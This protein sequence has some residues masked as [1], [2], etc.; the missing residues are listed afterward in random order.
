MASLPLLRQ[1]PRGFGE[2]LQRAWERIWG[3]PRFD[4]R[5]KKHIDPRKTDLQVFRSLP[6]TDPWVD[7]KLPGLFIYL[8]ERKTSVIPSEWQPAM[9]EMHS[10]MQKYVAKLRW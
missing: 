4:L 10:E 5:Q 9:K 1:Y 6:D 8:Y 2:C 7:A 3:L